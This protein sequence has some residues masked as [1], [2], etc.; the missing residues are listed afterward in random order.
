MSIACFVKKHFTHSALYRR[1]LLA[2][3][4]SL[5]KCLCPRCLITKDKVSELGM[6]RD[7]A[8]RETWARKDAILRQFTIEMVRKWI[9]EKGFPVAGDQVEKVLSPV[10]LMPNR[11]HS[12]SCSNTDC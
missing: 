4:K 1:A 3:I 12:H 9:Y 10:S 7:M 5:G 11:V 8:R 6:K 2:S